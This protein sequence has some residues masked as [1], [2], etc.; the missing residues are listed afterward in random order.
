MAYASPKAPKSL[1]AKSLMQVPCYIARA[2]VFAWNQITCPATDVYKS[3]WYYLNV[4][5]SLRG[6][7]QR[8]QI[9]LILWDH[10]LSKAIQA[11]DMSGSVFKFCLAS[12]VREQKELVRLAHTCTHYNNLQYMRLGVLKSC[13]DISETGRAG[14]WEVHSP[15]PSIPSCL[16]G[17][18]CEVWVWSPS[19]WWSITLIQMMRLYQARLA[20]IRAWPRRWVLDGV[21]PILIWLIWFP[22]VPFWFCL[23]TYLQNRM[24]P[25]KNTVRTSG[26]TSLSR[27]R[28]FCWRCHFFRNEPSHAT[29]TMC[30]AATHWAA[31]QLGLNISNFAQQL[32]QQGLLDQHFQ[33]RHPNSERCHTKAIM[34]D[35]A[36]SV[37]GVWDMFGRIDFAR[38]I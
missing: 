34:W 17:R 32:A 5:W 31:G 22:S 11:W 9:A 28:K 1:L 23:E 29:W 30:G 16:M 21:W 19:P 13:S 18:N 38:F 15:A 37:C 2:T 24:I 27:S 35:H 8:A 36:V 12:F 4:L 26:A 3:C 33:V 20:S 10:G 25:E 7:P 6:S 14:Q